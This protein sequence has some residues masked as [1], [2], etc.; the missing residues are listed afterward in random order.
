MYNN[1]VYTATTALSINVRVKRS[2]LIYT[3][4]FIMTSMIKVEI[5]RIILKNT[6]SR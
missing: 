3:R 2:L 6:V 5:K 1:Y 4:H